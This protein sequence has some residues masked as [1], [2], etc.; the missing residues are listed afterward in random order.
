MFVRQLAALAAFAAAFALPA[1]A[2]AGPT[3]Q[4]EEEAELCTLLTTYDECKAVWD[5]FWADHQRDPWSKGEFKKVRP[6]LVASCTNPPAVA[7]ACIFMGGAFEDGKLVEQDYDQAVNAWAVGCSN[8]WGEACYRAAELIFTGKGSTTV[9]DVPTLMQTGCQLYHVAS[10]ENWGMATWTRAGQMPGVE[11]SLASYAWSLAQR[12]YAEDVASCRTGYKLVLENPELLQRDS[13]GALMM[14]ACRAGT[15]DAC[16]NAAA[17]YSGNTFLPKDDD[18]VIDLL[19]HACDGGFAQACQVAKAERAAGRG[20]N[21]VGIDPLLPYEERLMIAIAWM[22]DPAFSLDQRLAGYAALTHLANIGYLPARVELGTAYLSGVKGL[23]PQDYE[24]AAEHLS[25]A[26]DQR[27]YDGAF[28]FAVLHM[29]APEV[30]AKYTD[31]D[32]KGSRLYAMQVGSPEARTYFGWDVY[33]ARVAKAET[34]I[35]NRRWARAKREAEWR[36]GQENIARGWARYAESQAQDQWC[37]IIYEG[38][39]MSNRCVSRDYARRNFVNGGS[40]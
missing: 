9:T 10:C 31:R 35:A 24:K 32:V 11:R 2:F 14:G 15:M 30:A 21:G 29:E 26:S 34:I 38:G 23:V 16:F 37:G 17:L 5:A 1:P 18:I 6:A 3:A 36:A 22:N 8:G 28:A 39:R 33:E 27:N 12:C 7:E 20:G 25:R 19:D 40:Y 13:A 4:L